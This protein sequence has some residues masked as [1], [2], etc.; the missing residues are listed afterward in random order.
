[1]LTFEISP[2]WFMAKGKGAVLFAY[3]REEIEAK[4]AAYLATHRGRHAC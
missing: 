1:M 2:T 4:V 3:S